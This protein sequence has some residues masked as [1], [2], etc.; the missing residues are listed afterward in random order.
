MLLSYKKMKKLFKYIVLTF[1][2]L[3]IAIGIFVS[4]VNH[5]FSDEAKKYE[6]KALNIVTIDKTTT[7]TGHN[8]L[9]KEQPGLW[10]LYI[11]G[12]PF[13]R[14][15]AAGQ[16]TKTILFK[17]EKAVVDQIHQIVPSSFYIH[18]VKY[19]ISG[20]NLNLYRNMPEEN[21]AE[22]YGISLSASSSYKFVAGNYQRL[23]S[24]QG[25]S[26]I[27]Y[28]SSNYKKEGGTAFALWNSKTKDGNLLVGR[29]F[30]LKMGENFGKD[31][32]VTFIRPD[33]GYCHAFVA[34]GGMIGAISGMNEK[35]LTV[36]VNAAK[37]NGNLKSGTPAALI[38]RQILQYASNIEEATSI[39]SHYDVFA[40]EL[41]LVASAKENE[42]V[43]IEKKHGSQSVFTPKENYVI[44]TNH[45][46]SSE[47][48]YTAT[49]ISQREKTASGYRY[50]KVQRLIK[51]Q[52]I[53]D[54]KDV[55]KV[56]LDTAGFAGKNIGLGNPMAINQFTAQQ[57]V[58]FSPKQ[59]IFWVSTYPYH[60]GTYIAYDLKKIFYL[61]GAVRP[62]TK[63]TVD[64]LTIEAGSITL[65]HV[66]KRHA[67]FAELLQLSYA[68]KISQRGIDSLNHLNTKYFETYEQAGDFNYR[69]QNYS[70]ALKEYKKALSC[71]IPGEEEKKRLLKKIANCLKRQSGE[72]WYSF[73]YK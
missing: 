51:A 11:E 46:Q 64:S 7:S 36:M 12:S 53:F 13:E 59:R 40:D 72:T 27:G 22:V 62:E 71:A 34:W 70:L 10:T 66:A 67:C 5:L 21:K 57:S 16:L 48:G 49:G 3:A 63:T 26:D 69:L 4:Y 17:Q 52:K 6:N 8:W 25:I 20:F 35:G 65:K 41:Y 9:R 68:H 61:H 43:I 55:A 14:G 54:Y 73:I 44:A 1:L 30:D 45:F 47:N 2:F 19:L 50:K 31:K 18:F 58:I 60:S 32:I 23:L 56:L 37:S 24:Y 28:V 33:T 15:L 38:A 39:A 42:A 29:N